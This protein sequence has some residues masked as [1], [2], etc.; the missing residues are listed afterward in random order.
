MEIVKLYVDSIEKSFGEKKLLK[1]IF[2][3]CET[4][5]ILGIL[6]RNGCGKTTLLEIIFGSMNAEHKFVR[7]GNKVMKNS[8]DNKDLIHYLPQNHFF[9]S[10]LKIKNI[11]E[12]LCNKEN[13]KILENHS[14][15][16]IFLNEKPKNLSDGEKRLVEILVM[17]FSDCKFLILDE[18]F[19][20]LSPKITNEIKLIIKEQ[21]RE[22]GIILT[23]H[24]YENVMEISTKII[25]LKD[26]S[27]KVINGIDDLKRNLYLF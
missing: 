1:D 7:V 19:H 22:K 20:S 2:V 15:I 6:G 21:S 24:Q 12:I 25:L 17:L 8:F 27:T 5:E 3:S 13:S 14:L 9:P 23:D 16:K 26:G 11:I 10:H 4:G 18:P